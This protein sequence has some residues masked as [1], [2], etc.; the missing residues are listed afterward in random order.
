MCH[1]P[2]L[3]HESIDL[4]DLKQGETVFDLTVG[5]AGHA[6]AFLKK[7]SP[8]GCLVAVDQDDVALDLA[9]KNLKETHGSEVIFVKE[10]FRNIEE[11]VRKT[12]RVP[13]VIFADIGVSSMQI[14][15]PTRGFSIRYDGPLDMRMNTGLSLTARDLLLESSA[16][17]LQYM[18]INLGELDRGFARRLAHSIV[19][20]RKTNVLSNTSQLLSLVTAENKNKKH[21]NPAVQV[22]QS[23]RIAVNEELESLERMLQSSFNILSD[24]G[25]LAVISFHSLEDRRVKDFMKHWAQNCFC[26]PKQ[27]ICTCHQTF[28]KRL[29]LVKPFPASPQQKEIDSNPRSRSAL[30]R[31]AKIVIS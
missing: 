9:R 3:L 22:F 13:N 10:N 28:P 15:D 17:E 11:I 21:K 14:D 29:K 2:V 1:T 18:F 24:S 16:D 12:G 31:V 19:Q 25:R 26:P 20:F 30:L 4:L 6:S 5:N 27:V 8:N 23:L 7:I